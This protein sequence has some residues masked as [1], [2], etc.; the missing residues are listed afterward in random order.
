MISVIVPVYNTQAYLQDCLES[1]QRQSFTDFEA[2][3]IDDGSRDS[4]GDICDHFAR[5][6]QRFRVFH[7]ENGGVSNARNV[8]LDHA[9]GDYI[10]FLDSDDWMEPD[11]LEILFSMVDGSGRDAAICD[12][13]NVDGK[14]RIKARLSGNLPNHMEGKEINRVFLGLSGTLW[15]K[16]LGRACIGDTRFCKE[17]HYGEDICFLQDI[18]GRISTLHATD[19]PLYNYRR[20][21]EGNVV[22]SRLSSKYADLIQTMEM[23]VD[24]LMENGYYIEAVSRIRLCAGR[25]LKASAYAP[26]SESAQYRAR[27]QALL[28]KGCGKAHY[29]LK[30]H[31]LSPVTRCIRFFEYCVCLI[32][33][34][35]VV[36]LY[37]IIFRLKKGRGV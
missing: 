7:L 12:A 21:R 5:K 37:K 31:A 1:L 25:V 15:N 22:A 14:V 26:L 9:R 30:N 27:C 35:T 28:R 16:L 19:K 3:V 23:A 4:S 6:D 8:A 10:A 17:L 11:M 24:F 32:S 18:S 20:M 2:L 36:L 34:A 13:F 33:P 29:L